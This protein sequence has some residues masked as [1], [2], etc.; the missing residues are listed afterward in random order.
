ML[1]L[2]VRTVDVNNDGEIDVDREATHLDQSRLGTLGRRRVVGLDDAILGKRSGAGSLRVDV[3][4]TGAIDGYLDRNHTAFHLLVVHLAHS[5]LLQLL[6][7]KRHKTEATALAGLVASL[8]LL[9]HV[10]S[11]GAKSDLGSGGVVGREE[12]F[13]L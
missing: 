12:L 3:L 5:L 8:E 6:R 2:F 7:S 1:L 13:E 4:L 11:D 10:A 9:H